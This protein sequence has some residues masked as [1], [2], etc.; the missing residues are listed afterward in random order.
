[1]RPNAKRMEETKKENIATA[2]V[3]SDVLI[4]SETVK[5]HLVLL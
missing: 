3:E 2:V 5:G 1:M 4:R